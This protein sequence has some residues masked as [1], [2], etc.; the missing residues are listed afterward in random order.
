MKI[1]QINTVCGNGSVG[2]ITVDIYHALKKSGYEGKIYYGRRTAPEEVHTERFGSNTDMGIHVLHT[3]FQGTHGFASGGQTKKLIESL[4]AYHP[5][6]IHLHNIHGFYLDVEMLF[7]YLKKCGKPVV[8]TL[9][10]CWAFTGHCA[11][12][13]YAACDKW[14]IGCEACPQ[15]RNTYPYAL[16][17]DGSRE[18][19]ARKKAAFQGV[20][21]LTIV[22]PSKWLGAL[23]KESFLKE[24]PVK[25]IPNGIDLEQFVPQK[26]NKREKHLVLGV[27][28]V[29]D[30]RKGLEY[31][32]QLSLMLDSEKYEVAAV[33]VSKKQMKELPG[34]MTGICHTQ[35]VKE[36][37]EL[38]SDASVYVNPTLE[39]N[40]PTTNLEALA[41]GTPVVTFDTG[42]SVEA[43][44]ETCGCIVQKKDMDGLYRA[45]TE[46]CE[47]CEAMRTACRKRALSYNKYDRF[48]E[49]INLYEE[50]IDHYNDL[51]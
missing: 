8:W 26:R 50:S 32:K 2:R 48:G 17:K 6:L 1:A 7:A 22:T 4:E 45:V 51:Q 29:W 46:L 12:F 19:Y 27:A 37:M 14:K 16:F 42:G 30:R 21:G 38:Y 9:H 15:Y 36:L 5:D 39:D 28:N 49:Y 35:N 10:D 34:T 13:D 40:F 33:G 20:R 44:D 11:Y 23:V 41:C 18:N 31:L 3:F 43:I 24:Y 47:K 25:V